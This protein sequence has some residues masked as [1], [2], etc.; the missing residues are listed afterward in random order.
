[1]D[2]DSKHGSQGEAGHS[3]SGA[4]VRPSPGS[5]Q[6]RNVRVALAAGSAAVMMLG[7]AYAAVP[8]YKLICQ[9]TGLG[10][11]TQRADRAPGAVGEAR[12]RVRFNATVS[13]GLAWDFKPVERFMDVRIGE[14]VLAH[15][16]AQNRSVQTTHGT[17]SFNVTPEIVGK[18]FSKIECFC[19]TEQELT[20]GQK[21]DMPVTFFVDP[22]I[23][24]DSDANGVQEITLS[25]TFFATPPKRGG[26]AQ[27]TVPETT[28]GIG[29][30]AKKQPGSV[31]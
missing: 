15:Y 25:Y 23:L 4:V 6:P 30:G 16:Q 24:T 12:I 20:G 10:G 29:G 13:S 19:F 3:A 1:M 9:A 28:P 2:S 22:G 8:I 26:L 21:V 11:T 14:P 27:T 17:A 5:P 7:A 31:E 18:Y